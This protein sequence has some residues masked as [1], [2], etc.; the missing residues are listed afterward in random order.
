MDSPPSEADGKA[1]GEE[2]FEWRNDQL[3]GKAFGGG[4]I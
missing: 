3:E 4:K 2:R 1:L